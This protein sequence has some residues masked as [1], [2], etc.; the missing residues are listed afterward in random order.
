LFLSASA[1]PVK[2]AVL[3]V[4]GS[5]TG[6]CLGSYESIRRLCG[7]GN[8]SAYRT[9]GGAAQVAQPG[10]NVVLRDGTYSEQLLPARSGVPG[11]YVTYRS[12]QDE[13]PIISGL[14]L[15]PAIDLSNRQYIIIEGLKI[16]DV[17]RWMYALG[18]Q[19]NIIRNNKFLRAKDAGGSSKTGLF[20]QNATFN[21][22]LGNSFE[23]STQ[24][25]LSLVN[26]DRNLVEGNTFL[27]AAHTL[28]TIKCGNFNVLRN[29]YF[30]NQVQKIGEI[31]DCD[32]VGFD[33]D[34]TKRDA[35][36]HNLVEGNDFA[37]T[38]SSGNA[39]PYA[40]IQYAAQDGIIRFNRFHDTVGP[41][42]D[43][44][45]YAGEAEYNTDNRVYH[46]VFYSTSFAG[47]SLATGG[48]F[49]GNIFKNNILA[50]SR[51][52]ANDTRWSWY[53]NELSGKYVQLLTA[54]T[55][56]FLFEGNAFFGATGNNESYLITYG[57]R[58]S[59]TNPAQHP[60]SWWQSNYPSIFR[61]NIEGDPLFDDEAGRDFHLAH[62]SSLVDAG[63]FL[64]RTAGAGSGTRITVEDVNTF[65]D[66]FG[67]PG[68]SGDLVQLEGSTR[69]VRITGVDYA[70]KVITVSESLTWGDQQYLH[71]PFSGN[72]PDIGAY[73]TTGITFLRIPNPPEELLISTP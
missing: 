47:V 39:S 41:G 52:V 37:Y 73:E 12:Y 18:A 33:H 29:N 16:Q 69:T 43:F 23:D 5:I 67:I 24:D 44:T 59:G 21:K 36:K 66:G 38:A 7:T 34:V 14:S 11:Q 48:N 1:Y 25:H 27:K 65:Y 31:Y 55:D 50:R 32:A 17:N 13:Y 62:N 63:S 2:A 64:T 45:S 15:S 54:R 72:R 35:T 58:N 68:E 51:F 26:S 30:H 8:E 46:N 61:N 4:D 9:L 40:G 53:V 42:L 6:N 28:W 71:L 49:S 20:F 57:T 56:G 10:D 19:Y 3:Y 70:T 60:L 22:I